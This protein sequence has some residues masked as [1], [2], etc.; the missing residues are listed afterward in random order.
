MAQ[1]TTNYIN[2]FIEVADD[3]PVVCGEVPPKN[4]DS[5]SISYMQFDLII[6][7]PYK[8][9]SDEII[10]QIYAER[11]KIQ[12]DKIEK[13][14]VNFFSKGQPCMRSSPLTKRYGWGLHSN[15]DGKI[16]LYGVETKEYQMFCQNP[17]IR[18]IK[19]MR[20]RR[21]T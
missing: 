13:A 5:K 8:Y 21:K 18:K 2:S 20:N 10:F 4:K 17:V 7:N 19:A 12:I 1:H 6:N 3:S 11:N 15:E 9:T 14:K 16:A